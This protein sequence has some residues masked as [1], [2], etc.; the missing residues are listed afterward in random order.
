M[1]LGHVSMD[2]TV[3]GTK[4]KVEILGE[5]YDAIEVGRQIYDPDGF[6]MRS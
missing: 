6:R 4:L 3:A 5:R 1:A 2:S